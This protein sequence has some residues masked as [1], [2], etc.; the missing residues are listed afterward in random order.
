MKFIHQLPDWPHFR[1]DKDAVYPKLAEVRHLQGRLLG[2]MES[3]GFSLSGITFLE[4]LTEDTVKSSEIEGEHLD[5]AQV[6]SSVARR[7]PHPSKGPVLLF[8]GV[9]PKA[10]A[11]TSP[12]GPVATATGGSKSS[13][14]SPQLAINR[15]S[16]AQS[17]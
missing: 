7:P 8:A 9:P 3:L 10:Q 13:S 5:R 6:R 16:K 1:F 14:L 11:I 15:F 4:S 2:R 17:S 12:V